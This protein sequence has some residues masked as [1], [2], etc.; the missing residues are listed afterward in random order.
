[1]PADNSKSSDYKRL[2]NTVRVGEDASADIRL[3]LKPLRNKKEQVPE[4]LINPLKKT[5]EE[6]SLV[7]GV[8]GQNISNAPVGEIFAEA[9]KPE[10]LS[11]AENKQKQK[12][13]E[14]AERDFEML[15]GDNWLTRNGHSLTYAGLYFFSFLVFFRPYEI[16]PGL[17][18]LSATAFYFAIATILIYLP[19]QLAA[20]GNLTAFPTEVK[21]VL[22]L[23]L[24][25]ILTMPISKDPGLAWEVFNDPFVKAVLMFIVMVN[26][27]RTRRRLVGL[28]WLSLAMGVYLSYSAWQM[29]MS[30]EFLIEDY[31]VGVKIGGMFGNPNDMAIH[32]VIVTPLAIALGIASKNKLLRFLYFGMAA[33]F[34]M[35]NFVTYSRG[36]FLG[37]LAA[38]AVLIW[39]L[40]RKH[41][42]NVTIAAVL[43]GGLA[44]LIAPGNYGL[45]MLSIFIPALDPVGSSDQRK[46]ILERSI[47][48]SIRNP[49][50]IGIGNFPIVSVHNLV[51]HN[52]YTQVSSELGV[53]GLVAYLV[54]MFS[55]FRK[56][57][58]IERTQF[59]KGENGWFYY[60]AIGLQASLI[61]YAVSSFFASVAYNWYI[62][63]LVAYAVGFRRIYQI[64]KGLE[65]ELEA[66]SLKEKILGYKNALQNG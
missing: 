57:G 21:A 15:G 41:R 7:S 42:M 22:V 66:E 58:A 27:L 25:A 47:I 23:T 40:G 53:V 8:A 55:P 52:A 64:E 18:F 65:N 13:A 12:T 49:W 35:G 5:I 54:F 3:S 20:E 50:G 28:I 16:I 6:R 33:L 14:R 46:E 30:G 51:S 62:Y 29:Y 34:M 48:V 19:T 63:Y 37:L 1:M 36:G 24:G 32:L 11:F 2:S 60:M 10:N 44:L 4:T 17:G 31:R 43:V 56:L 59:S 39:K 26:V 9:E 61:G 38:A 45:R